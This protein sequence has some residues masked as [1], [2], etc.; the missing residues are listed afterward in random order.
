MLLFNFI[1]IDFKFFFINYISKINFNQYYLNINYFSNQIIKYKLLYFKINLDINTLHVVILYICIYDTNSIL[2]A[3][4]IALHL[5]LQP[6]STPNCLFF[7][8]FTFSKLKQ[9]RQKKSNQDPLIP[10]TSIQTATDED[11]LLLV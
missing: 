4:F 7:F 5:T 8:N 2:P 10:G 9:Q 3:L 6:T 1:R 11:D